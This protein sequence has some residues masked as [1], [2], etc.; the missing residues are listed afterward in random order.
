MT[1]NPFPSSAPVAGVSVLV[2]DAG[3][4]LLVHRARAPFRGLWALPGGRVEPGETAEDAAAREVIEETGLR[5]S[6]LNAIDLV[7]V[8]AADGYPAY[9]ITV[10]RASGHAGDLRLGDDADAV[11]WVDLEHER[12]PV[13]EGTRLVVTRHGVPSHAA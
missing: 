10:F 6:G 5:V 4:V 1:A 9:A 7:D 11:R 3:R 2:T 12:L 13:T 8:P